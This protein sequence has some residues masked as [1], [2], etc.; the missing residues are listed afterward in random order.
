MLKIKKLFKSEDSRFVLGTGL[1]IMSIAFLISTFVAY[2][3]WM[4]ISVNN[5]FFEAHGYLGIQ[6]LRQA[7]FD[8]ILQTVI[9]GIP[10]FLAFLICLFFMGIYIGKMLLRPFDAIGKYSEK[11]IDNIE[12]EYNPDLFSDFRVLTSFSEYF[13]RFLKDCREKKDIAPQTIPL[14]YTKIHGPVFDRVF[15][16]HFL[17]FITM[18]SIFSAV[19][20][21]YTVVEVHSSTINLAITTL[22]TESRSVGYFLNRQQYIFDSIRFVAAIAVFISYYILAHHLYA[23]VA[24]AAFGFF[25]TMRAYMKGNYSNRVHLVGFLH[26]RPYSRAFNKYLDYI[27]CNIIDK[28]D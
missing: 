23:K 2:L 26:V 8:Q 11:V 19:V 27:Q 13:F 9:E 3:L 5:I 17:F 4:L 16:F 20:I 22:K 15:Y 6:D 18:V 24:G 28:K 21:L 7:Y 14:Q 25:S 10:L 1:K 12:F